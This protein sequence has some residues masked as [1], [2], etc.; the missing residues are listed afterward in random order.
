M[1]ASE[2][3]LGVRIQVFFDLSILVK[4]ESCLGKGALK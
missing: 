1:V 2:F 3:G 4:N